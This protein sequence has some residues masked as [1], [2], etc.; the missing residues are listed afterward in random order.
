MAWLL[1]RTGREAAGDAG[2]PGALASKEGG[3]SPGGDAGVKHY[4]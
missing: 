1:A 4:K 3:R 2:E